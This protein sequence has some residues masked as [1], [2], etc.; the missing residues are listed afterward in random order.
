[1]IRVAMRLAAGVAVMATVFA[2]V[3]WVGSAPADHHIASIAPPFAI[4][5]VPE[6]I[7]AVKADGDPIAD[8]LT[9]IA[10]AV[11]GYD[12]AIVQEHLGRAFV[13][14]LDGWIWKVD[15][16]TGE[17]ERYVDVPLIAAGAHELP[18]DD[19]TICFC[20]MYRHGSPEDPNGEVGLYQFNVKTKEITPL[21]T[22]VPNPPPI[23]APSEGNEG[24]VF[25]TADQKPMAFSDMNDANSRP[26]KFCNDF[27]ISS[28]GKRFYVSEPFSYPGA[29]MGAGAFREAVTLGRN[30][31]LWKLDTETQSVSLVAQNY[32]FIDGVLLEEND[33]GIEES[34]LISETVKFRI[35]RFEL[36]GEK[37]GQDEIVWEALPGMPDAIERDA[38]GVIWVGLIKERSPFITWLHAN[39]WLKPFVLRLSPEAIPLSTTTAVLAL[40]P[41]ASE[42]L[43][44]AVHPGTHVR[45]IAAVIPAPS[46]I[47]LANFNPDTPGLHRIDNPLKKD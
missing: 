16:E 11:L 1:M 22:R 40:S 19:D 12:D 45:D 34:V 26:L 36:E 3:W 33:A 27:D 30:G 41:D 5:D 25:A 29:S 38:A 31:R 6:S 14:A 37:A 10:T 42:P 17:A 9:T 7:L 2:A 20:A 47:Y 23:A 39:P 8:T 21:L 13:T 46:G 24:T 32:T 44:Y 4:G 28:D 43:W 18:G 35:L 15:L